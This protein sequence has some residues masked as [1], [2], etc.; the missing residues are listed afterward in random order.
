MFQFMI[1]FFFPDVLFLPNNA[2]YILCFFFFWEVPILYD[3]L[4]VKVLETC[5]FFSADNNNK[6]GTLVPLSISRG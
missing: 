4:V 6:E 5:S 2:S 3:L 1:F